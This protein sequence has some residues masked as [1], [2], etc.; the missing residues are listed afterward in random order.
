[1]AIPKIKESESLGWFGARI[2][3]PCL[4]IF[5]MPMVCNLMYTRAIILKIE[6]R[7]E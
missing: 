7:I 3:P 1:M 6:W 2:T 5:S 4:G